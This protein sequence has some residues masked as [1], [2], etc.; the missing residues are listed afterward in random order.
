[1][2]LK[3]QIDKICSGYVRIEMNDYD[4]AL[5]EMTSEGADS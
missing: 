4:K 3:R 5:K 1:M 2:Q